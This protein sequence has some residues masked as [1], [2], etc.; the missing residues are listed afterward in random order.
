MRHQPP[1]FG[2]QSPELGVDLCRVERREAQAL[3]LGD[4]SEQPSHHLAEA[5]CP[6]QIG[7]IGRQIDAGQYDLAVARF[8]ETARLIG[9][10]AHRHRSVGSAGVRDDAKG[11]AMVTALLNMQKGAA[12]P[13]KAVDEM[14]RRLLKIRWRSTLGAV[15]MHLELGT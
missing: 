12:L 7:A 2:E 5:R 1:F 10:A 15:A 14:A 8:N 13:F 11:A 3:E 6:R 9:D 4:R